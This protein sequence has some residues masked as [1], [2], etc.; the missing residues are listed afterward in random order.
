MDGTSLVTPELI[1][2]GTSIA[3]NGSGYT[4]V[5]DLQFHRGYMSLYIV[6]GGTGTATIIPEVSHDPVGVL[7]ADRTWVQPYDSAGDLISVVTGLT[8]SSGPGSNGKVVYPVTLPVC[9]AARFK[10]TETGGAAAITP[11]IR[12]ARQ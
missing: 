6:A 7:D 10:I 1:Y 5:M 8:T 12:A 4:T 3:A 11:I 9:I 2:N